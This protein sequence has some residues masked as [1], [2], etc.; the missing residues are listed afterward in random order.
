MKDK[1]LE[2]LE[3]EKSKR[4]ILK[5]RSGEVKKKLEPMTED[6]KYAWEYEIEQYRKQKRKELFWTV[7]AVLGVLAFALQLL[8]IYEKLL[9]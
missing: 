4:E 8:A 5:L 1:I 2:A 3:L 9:M 6:Q 7:G